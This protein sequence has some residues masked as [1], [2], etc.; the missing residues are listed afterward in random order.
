[1]T[2]HFH[3]V[4]W[5]DHRQARIIHF[6]A[7]KVDETVVRPHNPTRQ[8]HHKANSIGTRLRI[9]ISFIAR[10]RQWPARMRC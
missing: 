8:V 7:D 2:G 9:R 3:A 6:N 5:I 10:P 1:M 4:V